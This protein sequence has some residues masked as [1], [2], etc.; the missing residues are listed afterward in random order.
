MYINDPTSPHGDRDSRVHGGIVCG[1]GGAGGNI[2][3]G[4]VEE[5]WNTVTEFYVAARTN[6]LDARTA[7]WMVQLRSE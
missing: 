6:R 7:T 2:H 1:S 4:V 3:G 5:K